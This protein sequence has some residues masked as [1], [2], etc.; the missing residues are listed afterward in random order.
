MAAQVAEQRSKLQGELLSG[1]LVFLSAG[2]LVPRNGDVYHQFRPSSDFLYATG[3]DDMPGWGC[4]FDADSGRMTL[5]APRVPE[6]A[7]IWTGP[8]PPIERV[9]AEAG[10]DDAVYADELAALVARRGG[11]RLL[12]VLEG[13]ERALEAA[14]VDVG[15]E[16][17]GGGPRVTADFLR[18]A[19]S[20]SRARK[21][22]AEVCVH[23]GGAALESG[24][25][26]RCR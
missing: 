6:E 5:V 2:D 10:A 16:D 23:V 15:G 24:P 11:S 18:G 14:G 3:L 8:T 26:C 21:T 1:G 17:G 12:H 7:A 20:R 25:L 13:G 19:L 9:A 4:L 22:R